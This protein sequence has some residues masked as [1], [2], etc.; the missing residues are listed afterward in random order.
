MNALVVLEDVYS[1][2]DNLASKIF[3]T[4]LVMFLFGCMLGYGLEVLFRRIFTAHKWVNPG[5]MKG[6]WLP[7]YGFG[8]VIMFSLCFLLFVAAFVL[9]ILAIFTNEALQGVYEKIGIAFIV[10]FAVSVILAI[11]LTKMDKNHRDK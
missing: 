1:D 6:P 3:M 10:V 8:V 2:I 5:F 11:V 7:L 9:Q 4:L